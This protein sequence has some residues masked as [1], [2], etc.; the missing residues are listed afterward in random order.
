MVAGY[1]GESIEIKISEDG[2]EI[3]V[4]GER[5]VQ[6]MTMMPLRMKEEEVK[7]RGFR[8]KFKIPE[9]VVLDWIKASYDE[10]GCVLTIVMPKMVRGVKRGIGIEELKEEEK[11]E[12]A[13]AVEEKAEATE[14]S[15]A[16][17]VKEEATEQSVAEEVK[18]EEVDTKD[19]IAEEA[20]QKSV[21]EEKKEE[22]KEEEV[23]GREDVAEEA[24]QRSVEEEEVKEKEEEKEGE[25]QRDEVSQETHEEKETR[26]EVKEDRE[27][28]KPS[29]PLLVGGSTLLASLL[30]LVINYLRLRKD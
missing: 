15:V 23:D 16:E 28:W 24:D 19:N 30:Y 9:G 1:T 25:E 14:Q 26:Q 8:R 11:K 10:D 29:P 12:E 6:E 22:E 4:S 13:E 3:W 18:E 27:P 20:D 7:M 17:E 5:E 21:V 2:E